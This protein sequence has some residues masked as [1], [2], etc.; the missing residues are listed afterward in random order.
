MKSF[1]LV[2]LAA[3]SSA[4]IAQH[5]CRDAQG[6]TTFQDKPCERDS[7]AVG[8]A[9][10][11]VEQARS[12]AIGSPEH[13]A[14]VASELERQLAKKRAEQPVV[15]RPALVESPPVMA[16]SSSSPMD[17]SA[18]VLA[19]NRSALQ[20]IVAGRS[21]PIILNSSDLFMR[22]MCTDDG[23]V[24]VTCNRLD[25]LMVTTV[26]KYGSRAEGCF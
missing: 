6:R 1:L 26:S 18:C 19:A 9:P 2:I 12:P 3:L 20:L 24:I 13:L 7:A 5:Q 11:G 25:K 8:A 14:G 23:S 16:K 15:P 22:R 4:A 21:A 10:A 17:F